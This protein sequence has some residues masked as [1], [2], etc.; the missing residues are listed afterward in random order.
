VTIEKN[1]I[2]NVVVGGLILALLLWGG[3]TLVEDHQNLKA[4]V[5]WANQIVAAQQQAA[6]QQAAQ[7]AAPP[8][9]LTPEKK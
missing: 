3:W 1:T 4:V 9:A 7:Q 6:Q 5:A 8:K 2:A